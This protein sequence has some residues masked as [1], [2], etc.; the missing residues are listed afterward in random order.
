M[1][2]TNSQDLAVQFMARRS[3]RGAAVGHPDH[4]SHTKRSRQRRER[5]Q[6]FAVCIPKAIKR[7]IGRS[8]TK[9]TPL[10]VRAR[11]VDVDA[12]LDAYVR[13]RVGFNLGKYALA[14]SRVGVRMDNVARQKGAPAI[15]CRIEATLPNAR[16]VV[17]SE[18]DVTSRAAFDAAVDAAERAVRRL[19]ERR[20]GAR[21]KPT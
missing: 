16:P 7:A 4:G 13:R 17:V 21:S 14:L 2:I 8:T 19:L 1:I 3:V 6:Q 10:V 12:D 18:T 15:T 5:R 9:E 11:G 20:W